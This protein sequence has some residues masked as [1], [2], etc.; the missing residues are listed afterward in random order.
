[1]VSAPLKE[2][3]TDKDKVDTNGV[4]MAPYMISVSLMVVALSTNVIFAKSLTGRKF[5]G[6]FDWAKN[7]LLI[8]GI[9]TTMAAIALYIAIR[10]V[11]VEPNHPLATFGMILLA[12]CT[13]M[14]LVTA[15]VGWDDRYGAFAS[16]IILLLQLGSSAGTYPIELS[17]KFFKGRPTILTNVLLGIRSSSNYFNDRTDL[18][19]ST[20]VIH[21]LTYFC[22]CRYYYL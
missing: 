3:K 14:A 2:K 17:P 13:L 12:A 15:L 5:T 16:M 18:R 8:N 10:F 6:R 11:G 20:Y 22:S 7:K 9:I 4:G 21:F 19:S 1:M